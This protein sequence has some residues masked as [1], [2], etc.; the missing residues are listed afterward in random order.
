MAPQAV[1]VQDV[2]V[3]LRDDDGLGEILQR[4][5][6]GVVPAVLGFGDILLGKA[7]RQMAI[8]TGRRGV[9]A[10]LLS[11]VVLWLHDVAVGAGG[12]VS[13][14]VGQTLSIVEGRASNAEQHPQGRENNRWQDGELQRVSPRSITRLPSDC[15]ISSSR[16]S[17]CDP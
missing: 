4:E 16:T 7:R 15:R 8:R 11:R 14:Q 2:R 17:S 12:R 1:G 6:L 5:R 13:A 10:R 3:L 9:M